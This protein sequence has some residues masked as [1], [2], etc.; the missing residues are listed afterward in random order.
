MDSTL[1]QL[2]Q[3]ATSGHLNQLLCAQFVQ[4]RN[5]VTMMQRKPGLTLTEIISGIPNSLCQILVYRWMIWWWKK[6]GYYCWGLNPWRKGLFL[7]LCKKKLT[8]LLIEE[9]R[10]TYRGE[11]NFTER[12]HLSSW[13]KTPIGQGF[14][15]TVYNTPVSEEMEIPIT[16][17]YHT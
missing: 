8:H 13:M 15:C 4:R 3:K 1:T 14:S 7:S 9:G 16:R 5:T 11:L 2:H 6:T 17:K 10:R 12:P